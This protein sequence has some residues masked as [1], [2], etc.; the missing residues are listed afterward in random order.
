MHF[1]KKFEAVSIILSVTGHQLIIDG[2]VLKANILK[3]KT[4]NRDTQILIISFFFYHFKLR[5]NSFVIVAN[6][7]YIY[8]ICSHFF[9]F[10]SS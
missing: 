10:Q 1:P 5:K 6:V 4:K 3:K 7:V 2:K 9:I 8:I